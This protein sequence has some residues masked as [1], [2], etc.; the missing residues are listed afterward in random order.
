MTRPSY[1]IGHLAKTLGL[2]TSTLRYYERR[3]LLLPSSRTSS[4]YRLYDDATLA[5]VRFIRS[6]QEIGFTLDDVQTLLAFDDGTSCPCE[7]VRE[8]LEQ[9]LTEID[10]KLRVLRQIRKSVKSAISLCEQTESSGQCGVLT[11]IGSEETG[12]NSSKPR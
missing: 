10:Q 8:L 7:N 9:R 4:N 2:P 1:T 5:R 11:R 3:G 12:K 6:A